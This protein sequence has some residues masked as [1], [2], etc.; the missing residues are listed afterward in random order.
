MFRQ[1][2]AFGEPMD[3]DAAIRLLTQERLEA[4]S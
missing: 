4:A 1:G 2:F 3:A